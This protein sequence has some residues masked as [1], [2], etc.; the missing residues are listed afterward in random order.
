MP[1]PQISLQQPNTNTGIASTVAAGTPLV[2]GADATSIS[3]LMLYLK[4]VPNHKIEEL[5]S[6]GNVKDM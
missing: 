1:A 6:T 4:S 3:K 2:N 5:W